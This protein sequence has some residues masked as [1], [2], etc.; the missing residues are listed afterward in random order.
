[1]KDGLKHMGFDKT[2]NPY[3]VRAEQLANLHTKISDE[4]CM[5]HKKY[6]IP[7]IIAFSNKLYLNL[8]K[9]NEKTIEFEKELMLKD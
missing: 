3:A 8:C 1:M 4:Y 5:G 2:K 9:M 7:R 6:S